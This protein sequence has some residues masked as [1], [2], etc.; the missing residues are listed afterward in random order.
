MQTL[1]RSKSKAGH[2]TAFRSGNLPLRADHI[3]TKV[4]LAYSPGC[5]AG[6]ECMRRTR[7]TPHQTSSTA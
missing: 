5:F 3:R 1:L 4:R 2:G 6:S 7:R